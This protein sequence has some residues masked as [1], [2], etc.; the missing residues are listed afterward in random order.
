MVT[1]NRLPVISLF[2]GG[3]G[4]AL[5]FA[6]AGL[7]PLVGIDIDP[8][9]CATYERN[10]GTCWQEDLSRVDGDALL[11]RLGLGR[12]EVFMLIGGPP[13]QGFSSAGGKN[14]NDPR[15]GLVWTYLALLDSIRPEWFL[16]ENVEGLLTSNKGRSLYDLARELIS[17][18][19]R[20]RIEKVNAAV[21]GVP[22]SRK[23]V[24]I[25]GNRLGIHFTLPPPTHSFRSGRDHY[26]GPASVAPSVIDALGDLPAPTEE[27]IVLTYHRP[28]QN[29]F[30]HWIRAGAD[31][32]TL[33]WVS[34]PSDLDRKRFALLRP[35]GRMKDLPPE[36]WHPSYRRRAFRR[37]MDGTPSEK[38]GGPPAGLRRLVANEPS[39][40]ITG[41]SHREF[42]HPVQDRRLSLRECARLQSFPDWYQFVGD[43]SSIARQIG[44]AVPPFLAFVIATHILKVHLLTR[45]TGS[46]TGRGAL[47]GFTLT[48]AEQM[49]PA[50]ASTHA[51]L[52]S[53][54]TDDTAPGGKD[55]RA[56]T[57]ASS[58]FLLRAAPSTRR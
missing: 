5:G 31:K 41:A 34:R 6:L 33:H 3:G 43:T 58:A 28:P 42:V 18:G 22:Q 30:Q 25:L 14:P 49:S 21:Y 9:A 50:L 13:C 45:P 26:S 23:R 37:V 36:L 27:R 29:A 8:D 39:K 40:T 46:G 12:G 47:L 24:L 35:G 54:L 20:I 56:S 52:S 17:L 57:V 10:I 16:F 38:R 48:V 7:K 19:Y 11:P 1:S 51:Y 32:V 15:N 4:L 53:L 55:E 44:N 2:S